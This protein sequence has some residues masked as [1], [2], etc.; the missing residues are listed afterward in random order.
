[1]GS[2]IRSKVAALVFGP[3]MFAVCF[4]AFVWLAFYPLPSSFDKFTDISGTVLFYTWVAG[5]LLTAYASCHRVRF[6]RWYL[7][8]A[9]ISFAL[10]G[11]VLRIVYV[12]STTDWG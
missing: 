1:M 11:V 5:L 4:A 3:L 2:F 8:P 9:L 10:I 6:S 7:V 12:L